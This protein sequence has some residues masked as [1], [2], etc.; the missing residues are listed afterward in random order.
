MPVTDG[1]ICWLDGRD[2]E[3]GDNI[4]RDRSGNG[5]DG[6]L[7]NFDES[8]FHNGYLVSKNVIN[9]IELFKNISINDKTF[10]INTEVDS[11]NNINMLMGGW[12]HA[13]AG[14]HCFGIMNRYPDWSRTSMIWALGNASPNVL[15]SFDYIGKYTNI[16]V[17]IA[18]NQV[19]LFIIF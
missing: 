4:W 13:L 16:A 7:Y 14:K 10:I 9:Y 1:L 2:G 5:N 15:S 19:K 12:E 8:S 3:N 17:T 18:N 6:I 11:G